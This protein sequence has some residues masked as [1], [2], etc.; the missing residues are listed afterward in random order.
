MRVAVKLSIAFGLLVLLLVAVIAYEVQM[1]R[2]AVSTSYEL[3]GTSAR[4][5]LAAAQ[6]LDQLDRLEETASKFL[7]TRDPRYKEAFAQTAAEFGE[8]VRATPRRRLTDREALELARLRLLWSEFPDHAARFEDAVAR[9]DRQ[10]AADEQ[11]GV[12]QAVTALRL[13]SRKLGD[14]SREAV[15]IRLERSAHAASEAERVSFGMAVAAVVLSVVVAAWIIRSILRALRRLQQATHRAAEGDF[16]FRLEDRRGDEFGRLARDFNGM[17]EKLG[18]LDRMKR[19][20]LSKVSHDLKTPLASMQE[21]SR[22]MLDGVPGELTPKQRRLLELNLQSGNRLSG[23]I[24]KILDLSAMEAGAV[25]HEMVRQD[26]LG[27]V[28]HAAEA[29]APALAESQLEILTE[30]PDAPVMVECDAE[31]IL[32]V[33]DNLIENAIKFSPEG[34]VIRVEVDLIG[35]RPDGFPPERWKDAAPRGLGGARVALVSVSD[36]GP[37]VPPA[38]RERIFERFYQSPGT[39]KARNRGVGLGLAICRE[40]L[41]A[42]R[43]AIWVREAYGGGSCFQF[44]LPDASLEVPEARPS[45]AEASR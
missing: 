38:D 27:L 8:L 34:G 13:Q 17:M 10:R 16:G 30:L 5:E 18:E 32:R 21:T 28:R 37:G 44:A 45:I 42:H 20:F 7:V 6:Q 23:M 29:A 40:I 41:D 24:A 25:E 9:E 15:R 31:R 43:G 1:T 3:S 39:R 2:R 33:L 4:L 12:L 35:N 36:A 14:A 19:D 26:L 11:S 22:I